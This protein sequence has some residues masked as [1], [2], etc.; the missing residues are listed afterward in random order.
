ML[1][2]IQHMGVA[3]VVLIALDKGF[4]AER[5]VLCQMSDMFRFATGWLR[6]KPSLIVRRSAFTEIK[7][8]SIHR[9]AKP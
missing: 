4:V 3:G 6:G 1:L 5:F 9:R 8:F 7:L 2:S